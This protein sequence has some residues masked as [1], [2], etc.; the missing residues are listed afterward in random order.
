MFGHHEVAKLMKLHA[1]VLVLVGDER[2]PLEHFLSHIVQ[3]QHHENAHHLQ[4]SEL[5]GVILIQHQERPPECGEAR[6][7]VGA[8]QVVCL[9]ELLLRDLR[10]VP[11][12]MILT[13]LIHRAIEVVCGGRRGGARACSSRKEARA[14]RGYENSAPAWCMHI[15][16]VSRLS[17]FLLPSPMAHPSRHI[18]SAW[19]TEEL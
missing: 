8:D 14:G 2:Q 5:P 16:P 4:L 18:S 3:V 12:I 9:L 13:H 17:L 7:E 1:P 11:I 19:S 6:R 15:H 10:V